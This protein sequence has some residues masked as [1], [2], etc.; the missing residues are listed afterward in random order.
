MVGMS[1]W[2][3]ALLA[4]ASLMACAMSSVLLPVADVA[5]PISAAKASTEEENA[6]DGEGEA[7]APN[8]WLTEAVNL[9]LRTDLRFKGK[10]HFRLGESKGSEDKGFST[11]F[12][13]SW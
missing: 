1:K 10:D 5:V 9:D 7:M 4:F 13:L 3:G 12:L 11:S 2:F 8:K 6:S